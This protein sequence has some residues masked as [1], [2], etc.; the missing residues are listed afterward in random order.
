MRKHSELT[1]SAPK[2]LSAPWVRWRTHGDQ[3]CNSDF[4][5]LITV[6]DHALMFV[7]WGIQFYEV[8]EHISDEKSKRNQ[9]RQKSNL[10]MT[11]FR[12]FEDLD[13]IENYS[14]RISLS[15]LLPFF[16]VIIFCFFGFKLG[17]VKLDFW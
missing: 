1:L 13:K 4:L 16:V 2:T 9:R 6:P 11:K 14:K 3:S 7:S 10:K 8:C 17:I 5:M 12:I 15:Y